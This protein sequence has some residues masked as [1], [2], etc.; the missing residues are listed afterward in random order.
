MQEI[1]SFKKLDYQF[2]RMCSLAYAYW[3]HIIEDAWWLEGTLFIFNPLQ[4]SWFVSVQ[5][6][7]TFWILSDQAPMQIL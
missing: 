5:L 2:S 3:I 1:V 7:T 4:S 6:K